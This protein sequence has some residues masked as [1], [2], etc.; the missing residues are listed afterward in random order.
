[1]YSARLSVM[2]CKEAVYT[3][4][5]S[6][7]WAGIKAA[8]RSPC[9]CLKYHPSK[10]GCP[11]IAIPSPLQHA[12]PAGKNS[13]SRFSAGKTCVKIGGKPQKGTNRLAED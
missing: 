4:S 8:V 10:K 6:R 13:K 9:W 7:W 12:P 5:P 3:P 2:I 11:A 1:M